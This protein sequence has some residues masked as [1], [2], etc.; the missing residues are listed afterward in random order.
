MLR[1]RPLK[2]TKTFVKKGKI[3]PQQSDNTGE[4]SLKTEI[5]SSQKG[6]LGEHDRSAR[7][8]TKCTCIYYNFM[9]AK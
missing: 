7:E 4:D 8:L 5:L 6:P 2:M 3:Y 9:S 1:L